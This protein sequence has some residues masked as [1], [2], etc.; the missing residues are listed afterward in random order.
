MATVPGMP[1]IYTGQEA[2]LK[3]RLS[4]FDHDPVDWSDVPLTSFYRTL[5]NLKKK[6]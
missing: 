2:A 6:K 5:L 1:L 4:F 3:K